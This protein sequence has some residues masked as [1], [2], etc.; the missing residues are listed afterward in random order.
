MSEKKQSYLEQQLEAVITKEDGYTF[1]FQKEKIKLDHAVEMD[2]VKQID[3]SI[4]RDIILNEDELKI[5]VQ[6]PASYLSFV[7][8][9]KKDQRSKYLLAY[10]LVKKVKEFSY[11]RLNLLVCP[12][13]IVFDQSFTPFILHYGVKESIPPYEKDKDRLWAEVK[14]T[15][16]AA[17]DHKYTFLQ[18]LNLHETL[19]LTA[20]SKEVLHAKSEEELLFFLEEKL[21]QLEENEKTLVHIPQNKWKLT[22]YVALGFLICLLPALIY[23]VYSMFFLQPKQEAF[24]ASNEHFLASD[25]SEVVNTLA[26]YDVEEMPNV[27]KFQ[28]ASAFIVNESLT[29]DQKE[30]V[31][32][33]ITLQSDSQYFDYWIFIGRGIAESAL[34]VARSLEDR[35]LIVFGLLNYREA[36]KANE[37]LSSEE[38]QQRLKEVEAEIQ[39]YQE[40]Q[41]SQQEEEEQKAED[42]QQASE[43]VEEQADTSEAQTQQS[44]EKV[45]EQSPTEQDTTIQNDQKDAAAD[46][47]NENSTN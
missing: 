35:D 8:I 12:E 23:T 20:L 40:E 22:R 34:D 7:H 41:A 25:Y 3:S 30:N 38:R 36:I 28:L 29:E 47:A 5:V 13:N 39:E 11:T 16:A 26:N 1:T 42:E 44:D 33:T 43:K 31:Q 46:S 4:Q 17:I 9:K 45:S 6:I 27:V 2:L 14:A 15:V 32:N 21:T 19:E 24:V 10:Q 18:Y 37:E